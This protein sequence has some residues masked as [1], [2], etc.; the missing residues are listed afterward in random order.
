MSSTGVT[1]LTATLAA[2]NFASGADSLTY[3]L[4][5]IPFGAGTASF[6]LNIGGQACTLALPVQSGTSG[7]SATGCWAKV[8]ASDT[9]FFQ[10]HNLASANTSA[11]PFTPSWEINGGYWQWGRKGPDSTQWLNTNTS[12]FAHGP[13][14]SGA[15]EANS[16]AIGGWSSGDAPNG[17]WSD[18]TKT[19]DDPCPTG[20]R[21]PARAQWDAVLAHNTQSIVG[22]WSSGATN[23]SSGRFFGPNLMLPAAGYR[24]IGDGTLFSRGSSNFYW[25]ST[26]SGSQNAWYLGSLGGNANTTTNRRSHGFSLRCAAIP[27][28]GSI[29]SL[30][31]A[32]AVQN[33]ILTADSVATGVSVSVPYTGGNGGPHPGQTAPSTGVTG[34]TASLTAGDFAS[35]SGSL[36]Y[37]ISGTP[38]VGGTANFA[39]N[40]GGQACTLALTVENSSVSACWAKVS[41]S[42]TL[43]FQC[44]NLASANTSADPFTPSWEINGGYWQWGRKGPDSTQWLNTNTPNFAHGPTNLTSLEANSGAISG[45]SS[46]VA[47]TGSWSDGLKTAN[48]PCPPGF[49]IPTQ[50]QWAGVLANNTQSIVGSWYES[51]TNYSSGRFFGPNLMLPAA[52]LRN[53]GDGTL[54]YRGYY[55]YYWSSTEN[56][57]VNAWDL[58]FDSGDAGTGSYYRTYGFSVRCAAE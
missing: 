48:D 41:A 1:G 19:A 20:F 29:A 23:Y 5:G 39:L 3:T 4:S 15:A 24:N 57:G 32:N 12:N 56:G 54:F 44:H 10:C 52:G 26:S 9:L 18:A 55:G 28:V 58:I 11:D 7:G 37:T 2:G 31:C 40:I 21:V 49:R 16:D 50:A 53:D 47:P 30:N 34:L 6:A 33:G 22:T 42:E 8:S 13:T 43:F 51:A 14:G 36:T 38:D 35:G 17:S 46:S 25:S 45:W 27:A